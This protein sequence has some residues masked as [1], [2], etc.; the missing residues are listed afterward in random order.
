MPAQRA[1]VDAQ[2]V[3]I[4]LQVPGMETYQDEELPEPIQ[5]LLDECSHNTLRNVLVVCLKRLF[6]ESTF[7][8]AFD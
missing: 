1:Q 6:Y 7:Q 5:D 2:I 3:R 8:E 4:L